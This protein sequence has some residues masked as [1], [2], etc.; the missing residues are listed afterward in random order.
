VLRTI[1]RFHA[2][3]LQPILPPHNV[4]ACH[5]AY[6]DVSSISGLSHPEI[7]AIKRTQVVYACFA[8]RFGLVHAPV[9][10]DWGSKTSLAL[11]VAVLMHELWDY[12]GAESFLTDAVSRH[13]LDIFPNQEESIQAH[14]IDEQLTSAVIQSGGSSS[15]LNKGYV[16]RRL[17][18]S[19][20]SLPCE[21]FLNHVGLDAVAE[22]PMPQIASVLRLP[23]A[24]WQ[25]Q[26]GTDSQSG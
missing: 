19:D 25:Y 3:T 26:C 24:A 17:K 12:E 21:I 22:P 2:G 14:Q 11:R 5:L 6:L 23:D 15:I 9:Q 4:A 13:L 18:P 10:S 7:T 1:N 8:I 20:F 16:R